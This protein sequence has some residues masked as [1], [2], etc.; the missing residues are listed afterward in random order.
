M[1]DYL[2]YAT[3]LDVYLAEPSIFSEADRVVLLQTLLDVLKSS[4]ELT[5]NIAW[6]I[7]DLLMGFYHMPFDFG[8]QRIAETPFIKLLMAIFSHIAEKGNP[9]ELSLKALETLSR[10]SVQSNYSLVYSKKYNPKADGDKDEEETSDDDDED[11]YDL[12][13]SDRYKYSFEEV[14]SRMRTAERYLD[15]KFVSLHETIASTLQRIHTSY[16]SRFF[17]TTTTGL[18]SFLALNIDT[19][20]LHGLIFIVRRLYTFARDYNPPLPPPYGVSGDLPVSE[21][22]IQLLHK[23]LQS[24]LSFLFDLLFSISSVKW[25]HRLYVE[26]RHNVALE[27]QPTKRERFYVLQ[28]YAAQI[29]DLAFRLQ[30]LGLSLD[31]DTD[32]LFDDMVKDLVDKYDKK[33]G[34][35]HAALEVLVDDVASETSTIKPESLPFDFQDAKVPESVYLSKEGVFLFVTQA[36]YEN[37]HFPEALSFKNL[38]NLIKV[39]HEFVLGSASPYANGD[40]ENEEDSASKIPTPGICDA[41]AFWAL[42]TLRNIKTTEQLLQ[43]VPSEGLLI[44]YLQILTMLAVHT[45]PEREGDLKSLFYSIIWRILSLH[46]H[47]MRY[48][49]LIDTIKSCPY[50]EPRE[51]A[52]K[53][54]KDLLVAKNGTVSK[55]ARIPSSTGKSDTDFLEKKLEQLGIKEENSKGPKGFNPDMIVRPNQ[56]EPEEDEKRGNGT[57]GSKLSDGENEEIASMIST[58]INDAIALVAKQGKT[59][60]SEDEEEGSLLEADDDDEQIDFGILG[61]WA[62]FVAANTLTPESTAEIVLLFDSFLASLK[63]LG[64]TGDDGESDAEVLGLQRQGDLLELLV[65][66]IKRD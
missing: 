28:N 31:M 11:E 62:N 1:K 40:G 30:Q 49:Y 41:L 23:L 4:D 50:P 59:E 14:E 21:T 65:T 2:S 55:S 17:S 20:S 8:T 54:L 34:I 57:S 22:E 43:Q 39:T 56:I 51:M 6:N 60:D 25:A 12:F 37:R 26:L 35:S 15:L 64:A 66:S 61:S 32:K 45:N 13:Y 36:R 44:E 63:K 47:T 16:P 3:L 24:F 38:Q 10:L 46:T 58:A 48:G 18:L 53:N 33:A 52:I 19:L 29:D 5:Y 7:P 42:W 27:V 9:K